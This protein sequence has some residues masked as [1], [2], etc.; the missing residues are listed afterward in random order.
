[1]QSAGARRCQS[2]SNIRRSS[3]ARVMRD[4]R[5]LP[6]PGLKSVRCRRQPRPPSW[7]RSRATREVRPLRLLTGVFAGNNSAGYEQCDVR[8][9][10]QAGRATMVSICVKML[11]GDFL[12]GAAPGS[13]GTKNGIDLPQFDVLRPAHPRP[14][15]RARAQTCCAG[16]RKAPEQL[17]PQGA[18]AGPDRAGGSRGPHRNV[19]R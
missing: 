9:D 16:D 12:H 19:A 6:P 10:E 17:V 8:R 5:I 18:Q 4:A 15:A 13:R 14:H 3:A 7:P 2:R 1:M 11:L